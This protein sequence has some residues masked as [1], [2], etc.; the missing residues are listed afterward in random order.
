MIENVSFLAAFLAGIVSISSPCILPLVPVYLAHIAGVSV[1]ERGDAARPAVLRNA[2]AYVLGFSLVFVAM[3]AAL[4]AVGAM[5]GTLEF[6]ALNRIWLVRI[7]GLLLVVL[8]LYQIGLIR[9]PLLDRTWRPQFEPGSRG[10]VFSSFI[11]GVGFG[12]GWSP[13]MT[14]ILGAIMTMAAGQGDFG[15]ATTLL[16]VYALGLGVP[17]MLAAFAFGSA[18]KVIRRLNAHLHSVTVVSGAIMLGVGIIMILGIYQQL[19]TEIVRIAP[20]TPWEP[21]L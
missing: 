2:A 18:P 11:I 21:T 10:T 6:V 3:G 14:P 15:R 5:A 13:C 16:A 1:G 8:G 12:A 20:W 4:G 7:G 17:F 19:F 9:I